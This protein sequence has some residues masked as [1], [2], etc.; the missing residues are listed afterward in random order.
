ME[1][2]QRRTGLSRELAWVLVLKV[3]ALSVIWA[4][5][6][7]GQEPKVDEHTMETAIKINGIQ[8]SIQK[9]HHHD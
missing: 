8:S 7:R 3:L 2:P 4:L 9:G 5:F 6:V 1:Q